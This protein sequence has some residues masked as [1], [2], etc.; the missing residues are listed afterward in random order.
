MF[1]GDTPE[2]MNFLARELVA[3]LLGK[4]RFTQMAVQ[5]QWLTF[6]T[7]SRKKQEKS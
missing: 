2:K 1:L 7:L 4:P 3:D 6:T 5:F